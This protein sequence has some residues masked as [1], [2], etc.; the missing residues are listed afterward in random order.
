MAIRKFCSIDRP[1]TDTLRSNVRRGVE[2][3][4]DARDVAGEG[5]HDHAAVERL[6][7]LAEG[8]ADRPL[9]RR[10]ARVLGA[11]RV[12]Q[13]AQHAFLAEPGEDREVGQLA[14][15]RGVVELEVAGV[16]DRPDRRAQRDAHRVRDRVADPERDHVERPDLDL[17]ARVEREQRVV[18]ELVLLDLVA[19]QAAGEGGG[20][21]RHARELRQHVR[22]RAD[23]VL[24]GMGDEERLDVGAAFLE[25]GD[26]GDDEVDPEHLLV[27]EHQAAV[28]DDDLVAV[29]EDVHVLADLAHP[30]ERDDAERL[31]VGR[32]HR[33]PWWVVSRRGSAEVWRRPAPGPAWP[34]RWHRR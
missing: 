20:V 17:V 6:H 5:R 12:G 24:V 4:L 31:V 2:D 8:L 27:G 18:V 23:V 15:D 26:V 29:L 33:C 14:V 11:G 9:G 30:A 34:R 21:D 10:V 28:D 19:E 32:W 1:M 25:V 22:Q 7:D 16:D 3:L 13:Q